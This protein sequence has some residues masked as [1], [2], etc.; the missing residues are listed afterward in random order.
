M[1]SFSKRSLGSASALLAAVVIGEP[2]A[3]APAPPAAPA[4]FAVGGRTPVLV[5][6]AEGAQLYECKPAAGGLAWT[7][8]EPMAALIKDGKTIGRHYAGPTWELDDGGAVRGKV[9]ASAP[10]ETAADIPLLKLN[11]VAHRGAGALQDATLVLR[12]NTHG[13]GLT[14]PCPIADELRVAP[15]SADYVFLP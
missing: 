12:L 8:R 10:G 6:H 5:V 3:G 4:A 1:S 9:A 11:V 13:G 2:A 15:Y 14:G 7:F